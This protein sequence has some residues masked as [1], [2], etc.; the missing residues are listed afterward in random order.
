MTSNL[1]KSEARSAVAFPGGSSV[2]WND[3]VSRKAV[4][5]ATGLRPSQ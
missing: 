4:W 3:K 1:V 2:F 5:I